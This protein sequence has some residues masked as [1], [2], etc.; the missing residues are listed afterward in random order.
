MK[1]EFKAKESILHKVAWL[2]LMY[3]EK[4]LIYTVDFESKLECK[5][6]DVQYER[7]LFAISALVTINQRN[8][9]NISGYLNFKQKFHCDS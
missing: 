8:S 9:L 7:S 1:D 2:I 5:S 3:W 6:L 4:A